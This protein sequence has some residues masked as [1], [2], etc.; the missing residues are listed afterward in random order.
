MTR[1][2]RGGSE[3]G[4]V[5]HRRAM[6]SRVEG[7]GATA[8][9]LP[10]AMRVWLLGVALRVWLTLSVNTSFLYPE[11]ADAA[12]QLTSA[13]PFPLPYHTHRERGR[14]RHGVWCGV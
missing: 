9:A 7:P 4:P 12:R 14:E 3:R 2:T 10:F 8:A 1:D 11:E 13:L 6:A 5:H